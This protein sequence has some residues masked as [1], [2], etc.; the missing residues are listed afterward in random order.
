MNIEKTGRWTYSQDDE[1]WSNED[2]P[3]REKAIKDGKELY[4]GESFCVGQV[5][6]VSFEASDVSLSEECIERLSEQL[7]DNV[8][9]VAESWVTDLT[10]EQEEDLE[11]M[12]SNTAM[13]WIKKHELEPKCFTIEDDE[14]LEGVTKIN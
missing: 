4:M 3:S 6:K 1:Y 7:F 9:E 10:T 8:G 14:W 13:E 2:C 11:K 12:L 5:V